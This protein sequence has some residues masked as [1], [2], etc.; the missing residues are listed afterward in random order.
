[1]DS[2]EL[3]RVVELGTLAP[4]LHNSQPWRFVADGDHIDLYADR[5][6]AVPVVDPTG[7][8]LIVSCG[9]ALLHARL[10]V[11]I[12]GRSCD[13]ALLPDSSDPDLLARLTA[14]AGEPV[15][16]EERTLAHA[17]TSRYTHRGAFDLQPLPAAVVDSL[18]S[19][20]VAEGAWLHPVA[21][22]DDLVTVNVLLNRAE[23]IEQQDPA[24]WAELR[25]WVRRDETTGDGI[26]VAALPP[27]ARES[28]TPVPLRQFTPG[29]DKPA[30]SAAEDPP[31]VEHPLVVVIGTDGD[32]AAAWL[33]AGMALGRVLLRAAAAG[34][35]ASPLGPGVDLASVRTGLRSALG[36][37]GYPQMLLRMGYARGARLTERR[38]VDSVLTQR[39]AP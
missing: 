16:Q 31:P 19:A 14:G 38:P 35:Q 13:V 12:L 5:A 21:R 7:R 27:D 18:R 3:R 33:T 9:A 29:S 34:V 11:R 39:L 37:V 30:G 20:A 1:M 8:Q 22:R 6:R 15:T 26:P 10:G 32:D 28:G 2:S 4:S 17:A 23:T 36:L 24:Y 25:S